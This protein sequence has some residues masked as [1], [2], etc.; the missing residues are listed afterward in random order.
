MDEGCGIRIGGDDFAVSGEAG[1][2]QCLETVANSED[3]TIA[4]FEE[5][6]NRISNAWVT[7][8]G[9]DKFC[10]AIGFVTCGKTTGN[11]EDL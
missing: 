7:Q 9:C 3:Q 10:G 4:I 5:I 8:D 2:D 11:E 6:G 1:F